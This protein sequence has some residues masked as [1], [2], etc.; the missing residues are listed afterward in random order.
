[1][2]LLPP[3]EPPAGIDQINSAVLSLS[4]A[5]QD[6]AAATRSIEEASSS[7]KKL[8]IGGSAAPPRPDIHVK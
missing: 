2:P 3:S 6:N 8:V 5:S 4:Q 7:L 1:M